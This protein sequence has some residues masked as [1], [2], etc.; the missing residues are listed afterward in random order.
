MKIWFMFDNH[1]FCEIKER[2][3]ESLAE[4]ASELFLKDGCGSLFARDDDG[5]S[6]DHLMLHGERFP[7]GKYGQTDKALRQWALSVVDTEKALHD[8]TI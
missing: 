6:I 4:R 8:Y 3:V 7:D 2:D 1:T 5:R